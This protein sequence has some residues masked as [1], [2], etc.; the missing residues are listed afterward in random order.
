ME[1]QGGQMQDVFTTQL[2]ELWHQFIIVMDY[3]DLEER[4]AKLN[5]LSTIE[6]GV[7][8]LINQRPDIIFRE[9]CEHFQI[10]KSSLT[11]I[12]DRLEKKNYL[13]RVISK[14]DRRSFG[15]VLTEEGQAVQ[16]EHDSF[17]YEIC[18]RILCSLDTEEEKA[19]FIASLT[20]ILAGLKS[21]TFIKENNE[22]NSYVK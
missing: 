3:H 1:Q 6:I 17:E 15:L 10:P 5:E 18:N 22:E 8:N 7:I 16:K 9:I 12:V 13:Q 2:N 20:K 19:V 4:Y 21:Q 11:S 14:R